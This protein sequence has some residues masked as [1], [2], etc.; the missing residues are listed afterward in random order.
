[1]LV[2]TEWSDYKV[3]ATTV[4]TQFQQNEYAYLYARGTGLNNHRESLIKVDENVL[5][6]HA[7]FKGLWLYVLDRKTL[8]VVH[9]QSYDTITTVEWDTVFGH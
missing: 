8:K 6:Q 2:C 1:M 7:Y 9:E 5:L 4:Q 3:L